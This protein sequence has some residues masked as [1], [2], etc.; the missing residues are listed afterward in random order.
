M[1]ETFLEGMAKPTRERTRDAFKDHIAR[2]S[3]LIHDREKSHKVLAEEL[4]LSEERYDAREIE[5]CQT[6]RIRLRL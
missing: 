2:G 1:I 3:H 5:N 4:E 6:R